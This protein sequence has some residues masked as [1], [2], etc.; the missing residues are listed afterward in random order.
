MKNLI[1]T[2][3]ESKT[4]DKDIRQYI[5]SW[6]R[7][8]RTAYKK[9]MLVIFDAMMD[10]FQDEIDRDNKNK[11]LADLYIVAKDAYQAI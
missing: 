2:I 8:D 7:Q 1:D 5:Q 9:T 3:K 10:F 11:E 4:I 6:L